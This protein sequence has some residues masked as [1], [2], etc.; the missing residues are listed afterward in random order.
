MAF[1]IAANADILKNSRDQIIRSSPH[2]RHEVRSGSR[3]VEQESGVRIVR[4]REYSFRMG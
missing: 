1:R 4:Q 2:S 3:F